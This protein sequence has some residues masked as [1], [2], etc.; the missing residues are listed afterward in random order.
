M[1]TAEDAFGPRIAL[2]KVTRDQPYPNFDGQVTS[3][4]E[5]RSLYSHLVRDDS[6]VDGDFIGSNID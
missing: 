4:H 2:V 1:G 6:H 3:S 5:S